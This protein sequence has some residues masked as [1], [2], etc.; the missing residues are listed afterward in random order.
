MKRNKKIRKFVGRLILYVQLYAFSTPFC[1]GK[2]SKVIKFM[3]YTHFYKNI[4]ILM[5]P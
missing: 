5:K 1:L 3:I 2:Y 4:K